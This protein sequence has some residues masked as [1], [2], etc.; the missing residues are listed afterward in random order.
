MYICI[1]NKYNNMSNQQS[2]LHF[3]KV[4]CHQ[5]T[6]KQGYQFGPD[7]VKEKYDYEIK[8]EMFNN[9]SIDTK[10]SQIKICPGYDLLYSY[11][12]KYS[13]THP[14]E[15]IITIGGDHSISAG[16]IAGMN[17]K[18]MKQLGNKFES[19]LMILWID[20]FSDID[21]FETSESKNLCD[22]PVA[23]LTGLCHPT[24]TKHKLLLNPE[25]FIYLGLN[26]DDSNMDTINELSIPFFTMKK[27]KIVG[28]DNIIQTIKSK[29]G[30]KPLHISLD[31]KALDKSI[32]PSCDIANDNGL[33]M[34]E[35]EKLTTELKNNIVSMDITEF[36]PC[37]G[38]NLEVKTTRETIRNIL[39][40][41]FDIKEKSINIFTED[42]EF[43]IYRPLDQVDPD[44]DYGWYI[45]R[46]ID[47]K[48]REELISSIA[49]DE[50]KEITIDD[51][52]YVVT[53]TTMNEQN[54]K[55]YYACHKIEDVVLFPEEKKVMCFELLNV[56]HI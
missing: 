50:I 5:S 23:S 24:L 47:L 2:N 10:N 16:T 33:L 20:A 38:T 53:R 41:T 56:S 1:I 43:L 32:A 37:I 29:I 51:E 9:S 28:M 39:I 19:D 35:I 40:S 3:I 18:Y 27:I 25:Q 44:V 55:T 54:E 45:L 46:G 34:N 15:K 36:N 8:S 49:H 21:T 48:Q 26:E 42:S 7:D 13:K 17:E 12:L 11:I 52:D 14:T 22:M 30:N 4:P 6:R 31:I